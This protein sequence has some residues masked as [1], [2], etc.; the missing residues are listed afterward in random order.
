[1]RKVEF[2]YAE[3]LNETEQLFIFTTVFNSQVYA[4][5]VILNM[6]L[7]VL[8]QD[9]EFNEAIQSLAN[10]TRKDAASAKTIDI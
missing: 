4:K 9:S 3:V 6:I 7:P 1:M 10:M 5:S 2:V 8:S